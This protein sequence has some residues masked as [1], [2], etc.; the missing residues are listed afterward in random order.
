MFLCAPDD[1]LLKIVQMMK[2]EN[3]KQSEL[4]NCM[5]GLGLLALGSRSFKSFK[6][7]KVQ[8]ANSIDENVS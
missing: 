2:D 4:H 1:V 7:F 8:K 3:Q 6:S 5:L